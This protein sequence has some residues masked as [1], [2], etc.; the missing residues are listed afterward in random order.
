MLLFFACIGFDAISTVA[1]EAKNPQRDLPLAMIESFL[2]CTVL[3]SGFYF[4]YYLLKSFCRLH[5]ISTI[6]G[7]I[8]QCAVFDNGGFFV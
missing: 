7:T 2:I 5:A 1:E 6:G 3:C 8:Q 4:P